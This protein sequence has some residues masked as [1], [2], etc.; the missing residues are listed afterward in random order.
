MTRTTLAVTTALL[1]A[2][3]LANHV[4]ARVASHHINGRNQNA[5]YVMAQN[6]SGANL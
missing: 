6:F 3:V 4:D 1:N 2:F 5:T